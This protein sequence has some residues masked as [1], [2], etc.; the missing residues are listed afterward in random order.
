LQQ[1][2]IYDSLKINV[3]HHWRML[4]EYATNKM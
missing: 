1:G 2:E 4:V 3:Q